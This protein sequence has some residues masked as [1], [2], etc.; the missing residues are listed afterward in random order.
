MT[1]E[2]V[3]S[4]VTELI[5]K[6]QVVQVQERSN[7]GRYKKTTSSASECFGKISELNKAKYYN[8]NMAIDEMFC[9]LCLGTYKL[10]C[11]FTDINLP[12]NLNVKRIIIN[13]YGKHERTRFSE[14]T[15]DWIT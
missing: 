1:V 9:T 2:Q 8:E 10:S 13:A 3:K 7:N 4:M 14:T 11:K 5:E 15:I 12:Y 6:N